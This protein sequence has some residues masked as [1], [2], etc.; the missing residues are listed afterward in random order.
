MK[1]AV[2]EPAFR[3][4]V[5]PEYTT[6][7]YALASVTIHVNMCVCVCVGCRFGFLALRVGIAQLLR[8]FWMAL[9]RLF[10]AVLGKQQYAG[11]GGDNPPVKP[12]AA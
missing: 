3:V 4:R 12:I 2:D 6:R 9:I 10:Q 11:A 1:Q 7:A 8:G 5:E